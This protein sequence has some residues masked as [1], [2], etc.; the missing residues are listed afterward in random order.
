MNQPFEVLAELNEDAEVRNGRD[1]TQNDLADL[2]ARD[3]GALLIFPGGFLRNDEFVFV[4]VEVD[5]LDR[6]RRADVALE[7]L[8]DFLL[9]AA[10]YPRIVLG[11]QL[12]HRQEAGDLAERNDQPALVGVG[13]RH[14]ANFARRLELGQPGPGPLVA[15]ESERQ[16]HLAV[17]VFQIEDRGFHLVAD[18]QVRVLVGLIIELPAAHHAGCQAVNVNAHFRL[19]DVN[20]LTDDDVADF[21]DLNKIALS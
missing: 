9:V 16:L 1:G 20:D 7:P 18:L 15:G 12:R 10:G 14:L 8:E 17:L 5:D 4:L 21:R 6:E 19:T 3:D 2:V 11:H 13:N